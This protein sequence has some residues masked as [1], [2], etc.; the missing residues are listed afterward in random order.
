MSKQS[1]NSVNYNDIPKTLD[2][3]IFYGLKLDEH[4]KKFR[5]AIWNPEKIAVICNS[6]SGTG[7]STIAI[8][9]ANLLYQ[10]GLYNG[11]VYIISPVMEQRQGFLPGGET[12]KNAPYMQPLVDAL[13]TIGVDPTQAIISDENIMSQKRGDA[14]IK[15]T[16]DTFLRGVNFE[17]KVVIIEETQ[18]FYGDL[19]KKTLTRIHDNSKVIMIGHVGQIDL[20]KNPER[21]GFIKYINAFKEANDPRV[22]ICELIK[23]YRGWFSTFCDNVEL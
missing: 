5:D 20:V 16:A 19:L 15:F 12:E 17:N 4:Q 11:I 3:H 22:E 7:K 23:N 13:L 9:T 18:N 6:R 14:Y 2:D 8:A 21:S 1:N 10:Y